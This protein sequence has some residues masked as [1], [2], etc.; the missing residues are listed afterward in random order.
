M[1]T[2]FISDIHLGQ[3]ADN[4]AGELFLDFLDEITEQASS[5]YILGDLFE[6]WLGDDAIPPEYQ[7]GIEALKQLSEG[8]TLLYL[9]HGNRDF[10]IGEELCDRIGAELLTDPTLIEMDNVPTLLMHGDLLCTDDVIYQQFR[11]QV[12]NP[13]WQQE[14]LRLTPPQRAEMARQARKQSA[15]HT[16]GSSYDIM[17]VNQAAVE[18]IMQQYGAR[19]LIHGHTHRPAVHDF[20]LS[21]LDVQRIVLGDWHPD[22]AI[23]LRFDDN[24]LALIEYP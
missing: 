13:V 11:R 17:D 22:S 6:A 12:R 2:Y 23:I 3:A 1:T 18:D 14:F 16:R 8:G 4:D 7:A 10:L 9:M 20:S 5:L 21:Q 24:G 15:E 19:R